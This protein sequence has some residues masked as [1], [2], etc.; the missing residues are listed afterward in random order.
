MNVCDLECHIHC[1]MAMKL[2][3]ASLMPDVISC[4]AGNA[5]ESENNNGNRKKT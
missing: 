3:S 5:T 4:F 2:K 1:V